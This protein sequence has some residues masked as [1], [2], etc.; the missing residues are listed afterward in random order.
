MKKKTKQPEVVAPPGRQAIVLSATYWY[1]LALAFRAKHRYAKA[2]ACLEQAFNHTENA[3]ASLR[4]T[5]VSALNAREAYP[6]FRRTARATLEYL[7]ENPRRKLLERVE[8][9]PLDGYAFAQDLKEDLQTG[10][11]VGTMERDLPQ[12]HTTEQVRNFL[13][14]ANPAFVRDV[15]F[16]PK[17]D[18]QEGFRY[19]YTRAGLK[20]P[21]RLPRYVP[22]S[23]RTVKPA[24]K[25]LQVFLVS[26]ADLPHWVQDWPHTGYAN[27]YRVKELLQ[28]G[29]PGSGSGGFRPPMKTTAQ[30][31]HFLDKS[32]P[33]RVF[34]SLFVHQVGL[35]KKAWYYLYARAGMT[36]PK[37]WPFY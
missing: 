17:A 10:H 16:H 12:F 4:D 3:V 11:R 26:L 28:R 33:G 30:V 19:L 20:V 18:Y 35:G 27:A 7:L 23:R 5:L 29:N 13:L 15:Y 2:L 31:R 9:W 24:P 25:A 36:P 22:A 6:G 37:C 32:G 14:M 34:N 8:D 21:R 1:N